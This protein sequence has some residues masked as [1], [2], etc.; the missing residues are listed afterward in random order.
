[1]ELVVV[2]IQIVW[3]HDRQESDRL[4]YG[5][6]LF[7]LWCLGLGMLGLPTQAEEI[8]MRSAY[9]RAI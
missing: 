1:M 6:E 8:F 5:L 7:D 4:R 3:G 2:L 9:V